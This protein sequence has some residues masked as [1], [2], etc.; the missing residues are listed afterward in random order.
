MAEALRYDF[1]KMNIRIQVFNPGFVDTPLAAKNDF[2][3]PALMPV[4]KASARMLKAI[5][6]GGFEVTFPRRLTWGLKFLRL[7]PSSFIF[8]FINYATRWKARPLMPKTPPSA[9]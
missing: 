7:F 8:G 3:M 5:K 2:L 4:E 6:S 9:D 1:V